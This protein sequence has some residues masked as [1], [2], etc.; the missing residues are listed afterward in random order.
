MAIYNPT[1]TAGGHSKK[2]PGAS[3]YL[4]EYAEDRKCNK[5]FVAAL[6]AAGYKTKDCSNEKGTQSSELAQEC[7]LA[8][9]GGN[10]LFCSWHFNAAGKTTAKRG[11][12]VWYYTGNATAK[13]LAA[14]VSKA[15]AKLLDLPDRGAKATKSLYVLKHTDMTAILIEVCF[16]D[17][18]ADASQYRAVGPDKVARCVAEAIAGK[19]GASTA[20]APKPASASSAKGP[21]KAPPGLLKT[22]AYQTTVDALWVR[23][24][25]G[26]RYAKKKKSQLT[27]NAKKHANPNGTLKKGTRMTVAKVS[28]DS[29]GNQWGRIPSGWVCLK[30]GSKAYAK[31]VS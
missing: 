26:Q 22:G 18:K 21:A 3:C 7:A 25:P 2:C 12:E 10:K 11:V 27:A 31:K 13:A 28:K 15:L 20:A 30:F 5:A 19:A 9:V 16:V 29:S 8:N 23:T 4:D 14:K 1:A 17:S 24:G 6:K